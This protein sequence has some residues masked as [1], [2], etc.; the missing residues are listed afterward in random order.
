VP[1]FEK[2]G[3]ENKSNYKGKSI[4]SKVLFCHDANFDTLKISNIEN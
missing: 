2:I 4:K 3:I 1:T